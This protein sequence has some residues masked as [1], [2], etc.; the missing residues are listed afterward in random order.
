MNFQL[1]GSK[2]ICMILYEKYTHKQINGYCKIAKYQDPKKT[3]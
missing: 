1:V 3:A 2:N